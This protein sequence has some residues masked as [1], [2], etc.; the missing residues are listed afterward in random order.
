MLSDEMTTGSVTTTDADKRAYAAR[1]HS[2]N[3]QQRR[4]KEAFPDVSQCFLPVLLSRSRPLS[5]CGPWPPQMI[6]G[7]VGDHSRTLVAE[8]DYGVFVI[9]LTQR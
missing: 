4:F 9:H 6:Y 2:W 1:S 8:N 7:Y 3:I 5:F